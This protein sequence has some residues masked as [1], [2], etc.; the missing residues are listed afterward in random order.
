[1]TIPRSSTAETRRRREPVARAPGW[2]TWQPCP[3]PRPEPRPEPRPIEAQVQ[4]LGR[5]G[6]AYSHPSLVLAFLN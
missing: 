2:H 1:M 5:S 6:D 3:G 4:L